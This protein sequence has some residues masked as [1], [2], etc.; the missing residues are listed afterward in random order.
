MVGEDRLADLHLA[1]DL[2]VSALN[3]P[4]T[5]KSA[6]TKSFYKVLRKRRKQ[7]TPLS[8]EEEARWFSFESFCQLLGLAGLNEEDSGGLYAIHAHMNHDCEPNIR[9]SLPRPQ[10]VMCQA[11]EGSQA[12]NLPKEY[13]IPEPPS[14]LATKAIEQR[15]TSRLTFVARRTIHPGEELTLPYVNYNLPRSARREKLREVYGFWCHCT[16]CR[17]EEGKPEP[18]M[19]VEEEHSHSHSHSHRHEHGPNCHHD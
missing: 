7:V 17:R 8:E 12:R 19:P 3:P 15:G 4:E 5:D 6:N 16:R 2:F 18:E 11:D 1:H 14:D 9:V 10:R 13:T